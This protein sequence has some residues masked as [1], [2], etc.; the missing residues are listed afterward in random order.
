MF[1]TK[2]KKKE[3]EEEE[4]KHKIQ[5]QQIHTQEEIV[6][7]NHK[8]DV[9]ENQ[10]VKKTKKSQRKTIEPSKINLRTQLDHRN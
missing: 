1:P 6:K 8:R 5:K 10:T 4:D 7:G 3:K 2:K 9:K